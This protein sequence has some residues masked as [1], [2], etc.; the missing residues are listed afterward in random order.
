MSLQ[1]RL[2]V[3]LL[4]CAPVVWSVTL[5]VSVDRAREEVNQ[6]FDTEMIRLGRQVLATLGSARPGV[7]GA[8]LPAASQGGASQ[9]EAD[10]RDMAIAVWDA[11]G[12]L[13]LAD[14]EGV[15]LTRRP[16]AAGFVEDRLDG[17]QWRLYYLPSLSREWLV[18][19][20]QKVYERDELV[21]ELTASQITPWLVMLPVLLLAMAWAVRRALA[22]VHQL[23]AQLQRR[24]SSDLE[25]VA[26]GDA[27]AELK[28]LVEAMNGLFAR[29][30]GTLARERRFTSDVAH[31]LRTPL[32]VLR[33]QWDV[34][35]QAGSGPE[36]SQAEAKLGAGLD[37]MD[38]LV[39]QML[40]L[41]T[42]E[43]ASGLPRKTEVQWPAIVEEVMGDC[44]ATAGRR[45]IELACEWPPAG[46][47]A[48]PLIGDQ[49]LVTVLLRN[50][51]D[52][53]VRYAPTGTTVVLRFDTDRLEVTND[54]A[55]LS[56]EQMARIGERFHR[57]LGQ[58]ESGSGL[59]VSIV[60]RIAELH[61]L[62][63]DF[64]AGDNG[65]GVRVVVR[66]AAPRNP[67][68]S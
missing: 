42:L 10:V 7:I 58:Q 26:Q 15:Q 56:P 12:R 43:S 62:T 41:S 1:K 8:P 16:D 64:A 19:V 65:Q 60:N 39:T 30:E 66:S 21:F 48:M 49:H 31:E 34:V 59:G 29:I 11:G 23:T 22:P 55:P 17:A 45:R 3:Y 44:L 28:P 68:G 18:A 57:P 38:R 61:G 33:A 67:A 53:A 51:L 47:V 37:R 54:G 36:R 46:T 20:G 24:N 63:V 14:H 27:P 5:W 32:A 50:L 52:N 2:L 4:L 40:A 6:L 25:P 9:G 13:V 35:R